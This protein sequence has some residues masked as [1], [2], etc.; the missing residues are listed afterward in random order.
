MH[1]SANARQTEDQ[2]TTLEAD[3]V[4]KLRERSPSLYDMQVLVH[5][6]ATIETAN[7]ATIRIRTT[8]RWLIIT[9]LLVAMDWVFACVSGLRVNVSTLDSKNQNLQYRPNG[10]SM[11]RYEAPL[12][13]TVT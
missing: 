13:I 9:N 11:W 10:L 5:G 4:R 8:P 12:W 6:V 1:S 3:V 2:L 7:S